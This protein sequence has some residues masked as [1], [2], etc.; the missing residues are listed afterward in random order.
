MG[1]RWMIA[2]AA[3]AVTIGGAPLARAGS[4]ALLAAKDNTLYEEPDGLI[5]NGSGAY[6]FVGRTS[7]NGVRRALV[8][9][10]LPAGV[11]TN[12]QITDASLDVVISRA[13]LNSNAT[14]HVVSQSWGEGVS[15]AGDPGGG[16]AIAELGDATWKHRFY[17]PNPMNNPPLWTNLGGDFNPTASA[18]TTMGFGLAS[19]T[20]TQMEVDVQNWVANPATNFG[21]LMKGDEDVFQSAKRIDSRET[22]SSV[23]P[24]L[25]VSWTAST[26]NNGAGGAWSSNVNWLLGVPGGVGAEAD[27]FFSSGAAPIAVNVDGPRTVGFLNFASNN[28][29]T[30][31][32]SAITLDRSGNH[33]SIS[34]TQGSH[35]I[36][37]GLNLDTTTD[38]SI[39]TGATLRVSS[40]LTGGGPGSVINKQGD[41]TLRTTRVR[42]ADLII[43]GGKVATDANGAAAGVSAVNQLAL[44]AATAFDLADNDLVVNEG[45][46]TTIRDL[47]IEGFGNTT[48]IISS[49]SDGSQILALFDNALVGATDWDGIPIGANA[50]LASTPTSATQTSTARLPAMITRSSMPI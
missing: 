8:A 43:A 19:F 36:Q 25:N 27:F 39:D 38:F 30:L 23:G 16:G 5:S 29:Y 10:D 9:F 18:T 22:I 26:W 35:E 45:A 20:S 6:I 3:A 44:G 48:G 47:V 32:G 42:G 34:V 7:N 17:D 28:N 15:D 21:W 40:G 46:Y 4:A 49:T 24:T 33:S 2:A 1:K 41:G 50:M 11:P 37:S 31:S 13:V 14:L 12:A